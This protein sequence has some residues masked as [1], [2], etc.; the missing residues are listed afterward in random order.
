M[1]AKSLAFL[2]ISGTALLSACHFC[3]Q[4]QDEPA[5]LDE[6]LS[7]IKLATAASNQPEQRGQIPLIAE[8]SPLAVVFIG[9]FRDKHKGY[10]RRAFDAM[11]TLPQGSSSAY[12]HWDGDEGNLF[13]H[14][15]ELIQRD[16]RAWTD[17][18][19]DSPLIL[20][21]HSYGGASCMDIARH[22]SAN[23]RARLIVATL[24]PVS[25]RRKSQART[26]APRVDYWS[27]AYISQRT[28]HFEPF[29]A[30]GGTWNH[31]EQADENYPFSGKQ[32]D[33]RGNDVHNHRQPLALL[34]EQPKEGIPSIWKSLL[35]KAAAKSS[36]VSKVEPQK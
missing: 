8:T 32:Y 24:D 6:G 7:A 9:G 31:C 28:K 11:P 26:R 35:R 17:K 25:R 12:Y 22:I 16:I 14:D 3:M 10:H 18:N 36:N 34:Y 4:R 2:F 27:N 33:F 21:G 13:V 1:K 15:T 29:I 23:Y 30:L 20:I 19:P 5:K